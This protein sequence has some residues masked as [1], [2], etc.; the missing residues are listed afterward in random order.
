MTEPRSILHNVQ[1]LR[2]V[3]ATVV[4]FGHVQ[5]EAMEL[6]YAR[7]DTFGL[8]SAID[9]GMGVDLFFIISGFIMY[10]IGKE[11]F[12]RRGAPG[13]FM[14]RRILRVVPL[15]WCFSLAMI[16]ALALMPGRVTAS[17]SSPEHIIASF[18]FLPWPNAS[19]E[20][21]PVLA[22]GW[23]LNFE[24]LFYAVFALALR[25]ER[26]TG[27]AILLGAFA[28]LIL[29]GTLVPATVWPLH[30]WGSAIIIEF[31]L[32]I[33]L[34]MLYADGWRL[35]MPTRAVLIGLAVALTIAFGFSAMA[36]VTPDRAPFETP[37]RL[38]RNGLPCLLLAAGMILGNQ[39]ARIG[40]IGRLLRL[41]GDASYSLYLSHP[42]SINVFAILWR[43]THINDPWAFV[44]SATLFAMGGAVA[45]YYA[46]E[47]PILLLL[48]QQRPR[49]QVDAAVA[50]P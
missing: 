21:L 46:L 35:P 34:A 38:I 23:T 42:F 36:H 39:P 44:I 11:E 13:K 29:L 3:A 14:S 31:L 26:K 17:M 33:G 5:H 43:W 2:F 4:L 47:K 24:M 32:G 6:G 50:T 37:S 19:G 40:R 20:L 30:F 45:V 10:L 22:L 12:G 28:A 49:R 1:V 8:L 7:P 25:F 41:G 48:R 27:I 9:W 16:A 18:F 15:Y